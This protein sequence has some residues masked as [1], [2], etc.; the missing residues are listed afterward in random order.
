MSIFSRLFQK[1]DG[2]TGD[3]TPA[4]GSPIEIA[5]AADTAANAISPEAAA[6]PERTTGTVKVPEPSVPLPKRPT[7]EMAAV[8][9]P[10]RPPTPA[11][12]VTVPSVST[13]SAPP[14]VPAPKRH[15]P[16]R[17][18]TPPPAR[19][20]EGGT[21]SEIHQT[22]ETLFPSGQPARPPRPAPARHGVST[23]ADQAAVRA[24]FED[25]AIAHVRPLRNMMIDLK[26]GEPVSIWLDLARPA[27]KSLRQMAEQVEMGD[28][29]KAIDGFSSALDKAVKGGAQASVDQ[30][31]EP[32]LAAYAPL[33]KVLPK[34]FELEGERDRREP[35][36]VQSV[37]RQVAV[38]EPLMVQRLYAVGLGRLDTLLKATA[39]EIAVVADLPQSVAVAVVAKVQELR[40]A[41]ENAAD[42]A[43]TRRAVQPLVR[44]LE[45]TQHSYE[46]AAAGWSAAAVTAKR[47]HRKERELTFLQ[48]KVALARAGEVD[49]VQR[50]DTQSYA[51]RI[52]ELERYLREAAGAAA[53]A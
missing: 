47:K 5:E 34:A 29:V 36:I 30:T 45:S 38:L 9:D 24:T 42:L 48:I 52:D 15:S 16:A 17:H 33:V 41:P 28:L 4:D 21:E 32:L 25:L 37:L 23:A 27:L 35:I 3:D 49:L 11:A 13:L 20:A 14:P 51:R 6:T 40:R 39:E 31:R 43:N 53:Q 22:L 18:K 46:K 50:I 44:S 2:S 19:A 12:P 7:A 8:N 10:A 1:E 26:W